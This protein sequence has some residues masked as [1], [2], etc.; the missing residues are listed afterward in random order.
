MKKV[1]L[2]LLAG[3]F[4]LPVFA[5][6]PKDKAIYKVYKEGFYEKYIMS[7]IE[8]FEKKETPVTPVR[9]FKVDLSTMD[10]PTSKESFKTL[11]HNDPVSQGS[12]GNAGVSPAPLTW[13]QRSTD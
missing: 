6:Q 4:M 10:I 12:T 8:E 13:N 11:W 3:L 2:S 9:S 1:Y 5:Q 7:G